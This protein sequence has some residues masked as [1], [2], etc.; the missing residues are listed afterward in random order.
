MSWFKR[1]INQ[2]GHWW[3]SLDIPP[4]LENLMHSFDRLL[5]SSVIDN[6]V[7]QITG[8]G[9]TDREKDLSDISLHNA[10]TLAEEDYQ[11][12]IDFYERYESPEAQVRQYQNVGLN[13]ALMYQGGASVSASGGV[14]AGSASAS[15]GGSSLL[16]G[17]LSSVLGFSSRSK[18]LLQEREMFDDNYALNQFKAE[19]ERMQVE[20]YGRYLDELTR[21]AKYNNDTFFDL[22]GEKLKN[23]AADTSLKQQQ[24]EYLSS[25]MQSESVRRSLMESGIRLN[26]A[27][28]AATLI[29]KAISETALKYS[30]SYYSAV[31]KFQDA[32]ARMQSIDADNYEQLQK[33]GR[34][35]DAAVAE[36]SDLIIRC[37]MDAEIF[38]GENFEKAVAGKMNKK[39]W[40]QL[41]SKLLGTL[42][43]VGAYVGVS[44]MRAA[45]GLVAPVVPQHWNSPYTSGS[46]PAL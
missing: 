3:G 43:G 33:E 12:K 30:D 37:G 39:D 44:S 7:N 19:T 22:F 9:A 26:D 11:R 4:A 24:V 1:K 10:Q 34:L 13:P 15:A 6:L 45:G 36:L 17:I 20:N 25:M 29:Q 31:A 18:Q 23:I 41:L 38:M 32:A 46:R 27:N 28:T 21:G 42:A 35:Y 8:S 40:T 16:S 14:G 5:S 2:F